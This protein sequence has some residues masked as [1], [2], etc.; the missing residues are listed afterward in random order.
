[1]IKFKLIIFDLD[2]T[3]VDTR[4]DIAVAINHTL[5]HFGLQRKSLRDISKCIGGGFERTLRC[6]FTDMYYE[7]GALEVLRNFYR[8]HPVVYSKT[9]PGV[10]RVLG[11]FSEKKLAVLTNKES[12]ISCDILKE[13]GI[14]KY[15]DM[16]VGGES[17]SK[18]PDPR[19]VKKIL[20]ELNIKGSDT[21]IVGDMD[22]DIIAGKKGGIKTCG[23]TTGIGRKED[24]IASR[25]DIVID[26][27]TELIG[28]IKK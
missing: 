20:K 12:G 11:Y 14:Y 18:K 10:K 25:P 22:I 16:V 7:G 28:Y 24:V 1:M 26:R 4:K 17:G 21:I 27:M 2:G 8:K 6:V 15:F 13:L 9:Y 23:V 5:D 3:L 19:G